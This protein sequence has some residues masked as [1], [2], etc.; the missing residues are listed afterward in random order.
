MRD[1]GLRTVLLSI[2]YVDVVYV[3][4]VSRRVVSHPFSLKLAPTL[5]LR[6]TRRITSRAQSRFAH[7]LVP[8]L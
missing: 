6:S 3:D 1:A 7:R 5:L 2:D 8:L 4:L